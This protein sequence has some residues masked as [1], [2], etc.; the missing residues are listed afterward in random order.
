LKAKLE[1]GSS[2]FS[3]QALKSSAVS[4]GSTGNEPALPHRRRVQRPERIRHATSTFTALAAAAE[5]LAIFARHVKG[6]HLIQETRVQSTLDDV[7]ANIRQALLMP[8]P[9]ALPPPLPL[10]LSPHRPTPLLRRRS[11]AGLSQHF[12]PD[13]HSPPR[14]PTFKPSFIEDNSIL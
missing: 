5:G 8:P 13:R 6:C 10:R 9:P 7:S 3:F 12:E 1:S 14:H 11:H 4:S 2:H